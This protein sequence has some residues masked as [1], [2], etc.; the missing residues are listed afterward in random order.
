M[1][2]L[3][4]LLGG[5]V[6]IRWQASE[7]LSGEQELVATSGWGARLLAAQDW[8][9][10]AFLPREGW[11]RDVE[12]QP[13]TGVESTLTLLRQFGALLPAELVERIAQGCRWE[14]DNQPF[15]DGETEP[16]IN[17]R[18]VGLGVY[19]GRD[20]SAIVGR[21]LGEQLDDGGWNCW[22]SPRSSFDTTI[23]VLEGLQAY[24]QMLDAWPELTEARR[25]GEEFLLERRLLRRRSTGEIVDPGYLRLSFPVRWHYDVLRGLEYF[26]G[27][28]DPRLDEARQVLRDKRQPDGTWLL[29]HTHP[30]KVHFQMEEEGRPSRWNTLRALRAL[31]AGTD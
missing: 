16:C 17:G 9:G 22:G 10:G 29:E 18:V 28:D 12:P 24:E 3:D 14:N 30:G 11:D 1:T 31:G 19:F 8:S 5:D 26:R 6:A 15:F 2:V 21:L 4:W 13:W 7:S 20:V 25:R 27:R 23:N